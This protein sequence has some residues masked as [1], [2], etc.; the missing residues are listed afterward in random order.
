MGVFPLTPQDVVRGKIE[1]VSSSGSKFTL[2]AGADIIPAEF[3]QVKI[4]CLLVMRKEGICKNE[5]T[6]SQECRGDTC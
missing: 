3:V 2:H 1:G 4:L 5:D 6:L